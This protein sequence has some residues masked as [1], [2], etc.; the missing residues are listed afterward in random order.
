MCSPLKLLGF[1]KSHMFVVFLFTNSW[2][3]AQTMPHQVTTP[4]KE[5][6]NLLSTYSR[7]GSD[8]ISF[9]IFGRILVQQ[10]T[11]GNTTSAKLPDIAAESGKS[12]KKDK[13][14]IKS[15]DKLKTNHSLY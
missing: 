8:S 11:S 3:F 7:S 9:V 2:L 13:F 10:K 4:K 1:F 6:E 12:K 14:S 15:S 5:P